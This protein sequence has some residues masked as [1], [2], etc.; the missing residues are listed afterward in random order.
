M[1]ITVA[2]YIFALVVTLHLAALAITGQI[3]PFRLSAKLP[4]TW[5]LYFSRLQIDA[6]SLRNSMPTKSQRR[7]RLAPQH[8]QFVRLSRHPTKRLMR[9]F[10]YFDWQVFAHLTKHLH[11]ANV[12]LKA[13]S[14]LYFQKVKPKPIIPKLNSINPSDYI[15]SKDIVFDVFC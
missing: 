2:S 14:I 4:R 6:A 5:T 15:G 7:L 8:V 12:D 9:D 13:V 10:C 3:C 1:Q 11:C